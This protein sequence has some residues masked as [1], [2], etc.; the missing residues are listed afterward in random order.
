M[1]W[2]EKRALQLCHRFVVAPVVTVVETI[3]FS[4]TICKMLLA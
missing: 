1:G 3:F 4:T 2:G